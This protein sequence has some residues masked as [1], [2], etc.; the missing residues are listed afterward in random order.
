MNKENSGIKRVSFLQNEEVENSECKTPFIKKDDC[1]ICNELFDIK[2]YI[3]YFMGIEYPEGGWYDSGIRTLAYA[4]TSQPEYSNIIPSSGG[5]QRERVYE[6]LE[7]LAPTLYIV[8]FGPGAL[9]VI[10]S[11]NGN[12]F[13]ANESV[14]YE[15]GIKAFNNVYEV[16][17]RSPVAN[18]QYVATEYEQSIKD[19][20][21]S[22]ERV[23]VRENLTINNGVNIPANGS[24][25]EFDLTDFTNT[26]KIQQVTVTQLTAGA[27]VY[28][29]E[30]W[31]MDGAGYNPL[32]R[33][34]LYLRVYSRDFI[35]DEDS[36]I[37]DPFLI[38]TDRDETSELH[39]RL[40]NNVGGTASDFA[41]SVK[42]FGTP[43]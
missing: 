8:N 19:T 39:M 43:T 10:S 28:T 9:Y 34:D 32:T 21:S 33:A 5:Y 22:L 41:V 20:G 16:R 24:A 14:I 40:V 36:D 17:L 38:Y 13:S 3:E 31:E 37:I 23:L 15:G 18:T 30:I 25:V 6:R 7:R 42:A 26:A 1:S 4:V 35:V 29:I 2:K 27:S 11:H 12:D